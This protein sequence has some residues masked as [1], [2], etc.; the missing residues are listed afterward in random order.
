MKISSIIPISE[1]NGPGPHYTIWV[2]GCT[3]NCPECFNPQ[4][5]DLLSGIEKEIFY[6]VKDI[7][8]YWLKNKIVGVTLSGGE[9]LQQIDE[10]IELTSQIKSQTNLGIIILTGYNPDELHQLP[11]INLLTK[12]VDLIIAGRFREKLKIKSGLRGS[13]NKSYWHISDYYKKSD[14]NNIP[15]MEVITN[16]SGEAIISGIDPVREFD[17]INSV[18]NSE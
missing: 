12:N 7:T 1:V 10:V 15:I 14:L 4:T 17:S 8:K 9:P 11:K 18:F 6:L 5:H 2:Q 13:S 3:L 16:D